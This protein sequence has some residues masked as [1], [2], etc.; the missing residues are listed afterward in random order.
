[1][2]SLD[3]VYVFQIKTLERW[4]KKNGYLLI[5]KKGLEDQIHFVKKRVYI[6]IKHKPEKR[7]CYLLHECGHLLYCRNA[8]L[9]NRDVPLLYPHVLGVDRAVCVNQR[10]AIFKSSSVIEEV[11]AWMCAKD[12]CQKLNL[13]YNNERLNRYMYKALYTYIYEYGKEGYIRW[14]RKQKNKEKGGKK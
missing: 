6:N 4:L 14:S 9:S 2:A 12:L 3:S 7:F 1:M 10:T 5:M 8:A 11:N 13:Y